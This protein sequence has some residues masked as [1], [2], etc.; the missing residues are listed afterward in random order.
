MFKNEVVRQDIDISVKTQYLQ[1][2]SDPDNNRYVF[3]YSIDIEN[4]GEKPVKLLSRHWII[5]D[6]NDKVEE[7]RG[8]GVVGQQPLIEPG[9][10]FHYTS[11]AVL[12]TGFGTMQGSYEM[13]SADGEKFAAP[14]P[15]FL[16]SRP[17]SV[18]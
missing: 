1:E 12:T 15:A 13:V 8:T 16:L 7:V 2:Q 5:T 11:G 14:I 10:V 17:L 6:D 3:A 9:Q 4:K 18:H